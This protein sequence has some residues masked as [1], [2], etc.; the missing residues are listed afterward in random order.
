MGQGLHTKMAQIAASEFGIA[1]KD[2]FV[3]ETATDKVPNSSPTAASASA[4]MYGGAVLDA[5]QQ[6]KARMKPVADKGNFAT[7]AE[8]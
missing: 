4:D 5:C 8:V 6:I 2:V 3:S 1:L 7:F